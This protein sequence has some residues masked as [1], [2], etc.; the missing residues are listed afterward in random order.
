MIEVDTTDN[1]V[2]SQAD[3]KTGGYMGKGGPI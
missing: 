2:L 3:G 1:I